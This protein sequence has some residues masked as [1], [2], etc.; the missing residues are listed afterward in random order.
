MMINHMNVNE[1]KFQRELLCKGVNE[2]L[3]KHCAMLDAC[4]DKDTQFHKFREMHCMERSE[5]NKLNKRMQECDQEN[6]R[7][8]KLKKDVHRSKHV[9]MKQKL[10][11]KGS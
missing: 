5:K 4:N 6:R 3:N 8:R 10:W 1:L 7:L 9:K 2:L 11:V